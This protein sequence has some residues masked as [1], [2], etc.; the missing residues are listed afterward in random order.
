MRFSNPE[1]F[2]L[3]LVLLPFIFLVV[4]NYR[5]KNKLLNAFMS[6]GAY[7][8]LG[9]RSGRE[10]DFFKAS[11]VILALTFFILTL[12]GP[13]WGEVVE[14][15]DVKGIEM[16]F[17]LDTSNSMNAEDLKPNRLEVSKQLIISIIDNF[18]TDYVGLINFAGIPYVQCPLTID[19]EAF[20]LMATASVISP[21]EE[22][23]TDIGAAFG[24]AVRTFKS[25]P[26]SRKIVILITDGEDQEQG[27]QGLMGEFQKQKIIIFSV[28]VG[29]PGGAPI[30]IKSEEGEITGW[31]KDNKGEIVRTKLD[32]P[33][34][35]QIAS[36]TGG[37]YFRLTDAAAI[38]AFVA[39]LKAFE[40]KV[41]SKRVRLKKV[42]RFYI[43][44][45]IGII[46]LVIEMFLTEKKLSWTKE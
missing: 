45:I 12:A 13:E 21:D 7:G 16:L 9:F 40:R 1:A 38:D 28:G 35:I 30:P 2:F 26:E 10:I 36:R 8:K 6:E 46:L 33:T 18:T 34:L 39:N 5:K 22:Q 27:W 32:E 29:I 41:L 19:Y 17:L 43:P 37:Q 15:V 14:H 4:Y 3:L 23:G 25:S 44:L 24:L 20:K 11:L 42:K 31:K